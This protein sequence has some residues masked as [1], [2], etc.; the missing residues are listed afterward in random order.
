MS[1]DDVTGTIIGGNFKSGALYYEGRRQGQTVHEDSEELLIKRLTDD[2]RRKIADCGAA[3]DY[4]YP[5]NNAWEIR[6]YN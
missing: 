2:V 4:V 1:D 3:V 6:F 5:D